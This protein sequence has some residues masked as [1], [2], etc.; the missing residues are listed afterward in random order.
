MLLGGVVVAAGSWWMGSRLTAAA[1]RPVPAPADLAVE[2]VRIPEA[3]SAGLAAWWAPADPER[4]AVVL[5]HSIRVDRRSMLPRARLL[6]REGL[7]VLLVD[8]QAHGES[9]GERITLGFRESGNARAAL[10]WLKERRPHGRVAV[11]GASL[12]GAAVLLG[13][14]PIG[15]D[16]AVVEA[17]YPDIR[18]ALENRVRLR[19]GPLA[20]IFAPLLVAQLRPRLGAGAEDLRPIDG[21][22]RLGAP[23]LVVAG[24]LDRHT[25]LAESEALFAAAAAPKE[26]WIVAGAHHQDFLAKDPDGYRERVIGFLRRYLRL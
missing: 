10:A 16:A 2:S 14:Q 19:L 3:S 15:V 25:T 13:P 7:S 12:G 17:V 24:E 11:I 4:G 1:N 5:L 9:P 18:I 21:I 20:S 22:A 6:R 23:V 26:L 8:L